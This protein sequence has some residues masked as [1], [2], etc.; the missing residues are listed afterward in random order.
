LENYFNS[1]G[2]TCDFIYRTTPT[3]H[4]KPKV[5]STTFGRAMLG[6]NGVATKLFIA[7]LFSDPEFGV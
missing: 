3:C 7:F 2:Y 1:D 5:P 4:E 6:A